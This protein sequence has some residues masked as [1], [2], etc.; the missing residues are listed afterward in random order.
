M[1][2]LIITTA[3]T[4]AQK[5]PAYATVVNL[6]VS[7]RHR[8]ETEK[9]ENPTA[10]NKPKNS[11]NKDVLLEPPI[12]IIIIPTVAIRMANH[13]FI[14]IFSFKKI[15]PSIAVINGIAAKQ[16]KVI[17]AVVLMIDHINAI[18][19]MPSPVPPTM[20]EIPIFK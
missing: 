9:T 16:S 1:L 17:A 8:N 11:P 19:A 12:D 15:K 14:E 4:I 18:I 13:T 10:D 5:I 6:G 3:E 7:L 20:P 2:L